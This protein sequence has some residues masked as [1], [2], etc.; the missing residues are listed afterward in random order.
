M[1]RSKIDISEPADETAPGYRLIAAIIASALFMENLDA[2]VLAT[3][4]PTMAI[5]FH[6]KA[7]EMSVALT[8]YL[9]ALA[10]FIPVSGHVADR[11]GGKHVFRA[12]IAVFTGASLLCA[13]SPSLGIM[14]AARFAQGIGGAMMV[15]VGRL[16]LLRAVQK[17]DLIAAS[18]WLVMP[19]ILGGILG[20]PLG[21]FIVTY[22]NWRWIFWLNL[23]IGLVGIYLASRFFPNLRDVSHRSFDAIGFVLAGGSLASALYALETTARTSNLPSAAALGVVALGLGGLYLRH[24]SRFAHPILDLSLLRVP[25]F[26]L[27][28]IGGSLT[29]I[30]QGAQPFLLPLMMQLAFGMKASQSGL[31]TLGTAIGTLSMKA[32]V[33]PLLRR[34]GF[35][36]SLTTVGILAA[37]SYAV[38]GLF[39]P[40]W[41]IPAIFAVLVLS[42]FL[43]SFQFTAY[44]T[45]VFDQIEP[46]RMSQATSFFATFQQLTLSVG[47]CTGAMALRVS[48]D[49]GGRG[50]PTFSDFSVA[51]WTVTSISLLSALSNLRFDPDAGREMSGAG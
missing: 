7:P 3:A 29:R 28:L 15:P 49:L 39:R 44:N 6:V 37:A 31:I 1:V 13:V 46:H 18:S 26:R 38:C 10:L 9:L 20:P 11:W 33:R 41:P 21:G 47:I 45:I 2:T 32:L 34:W 24:A 35:R 14:A 42:G 51:F 43:M 5:D 19:G 17:R 22:M 8:S 16:V 23:P 4:L 40:G 27:S 25:T 50:T 36:S 30:T 12:A 48:M